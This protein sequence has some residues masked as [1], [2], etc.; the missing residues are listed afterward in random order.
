[1]PRFAVAFS[2]SSAGK[3]LRFAGSNPF[4]HEKHQK[5]KK[6]IYKNFLNNFFQKICHDHMNRGF[7]LSSAGKF[8]C[9]AGSDPFKREMGVF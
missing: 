3:F 7:S 2:L 8:L 5:K 9:F 4:K 1:M 6:N